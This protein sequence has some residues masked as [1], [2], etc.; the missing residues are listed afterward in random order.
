M[1]FRWCESFG[2]LVAQEAFAF[3]AQPADIEGGISVDELHD[4]T[5]G[6]S[7]DDLRD[8]AGS[9]GNQ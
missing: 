7:S 9:L 6:F 3:A 2:S 1:V 5:D 8:F 4:C